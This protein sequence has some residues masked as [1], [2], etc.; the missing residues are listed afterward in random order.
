MKEIFLVVMVWFVAV[1]ITGLS[2]AV[3]THIEDNRR[4][5]VEA[6]AAARVHQASL[7][8]AQTNGL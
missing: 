4:A 5:G 8:R 3:C 1:L 7:E 6:E 2:S